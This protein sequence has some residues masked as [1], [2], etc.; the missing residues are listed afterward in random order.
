MNKEFFF[1]YHLVGPLNDAS[2]ADLVAFTSNRVEHR[3][4]VRLHELPH[5][6]QREHLLAIKDVR[7][8]NANKLDL[9]LTL[10]QLDGIVAVVWKGKL[11]K[12][13]TLEYTR[14]RYKRFLFKFTQF[15]KLGFQSIE[16]LA[17]FAPIDA[18]RL[19]DIVELLIY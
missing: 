3:E 2:L 1:S 6:R 10:A 11:I 5:N 19:D 16:A 15:L 4:Y 18:S 8:L 7:A 12:I 9:K 14:K 17:H 13:S